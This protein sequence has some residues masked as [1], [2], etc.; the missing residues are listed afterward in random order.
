MGTTR[1]PP[2]STPARLRRA[3]PRWGP[4]GAAAV[5]GSLVI[6]VIL[7]APAASATFRIDFSPPYLGVDPIAGS[8]SSTSG[9]GASADLVVPASMNDT[10]GRLRFD[11]R[12]H[13]PGC[14]GAAYPQYATAAGA[15]GFSGPNFTVP[16]SGSYTVDY[17]WNLSADLELSVGGNASNRALA[18]V[19]T[20]A[21]I[22]VPSN[23]T[24]LLVDSSPLLFDEIYSGT[25]HLALRDR[26][27][28]LIGAVSLESG[29][30]YECYIVL[31]LG[32]TALLVGPGSASAHL[33][34]GTHGDGGR[35]RS[36]TIA[37]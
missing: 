25:F 16:V 14:P 7:T 19:E 11:A 8:T 28:S 1:S 13:V 10:T 18:F 17:A 35:L 23:Q 30:D 20:Y 5:V 12:A 27:V 2:R 32:I 29:L 34:F 21:F 31:N 15:A 36:I 9:C 33:N 37:S 26:L 22:F 3:A 6:G 24:Y 4:A